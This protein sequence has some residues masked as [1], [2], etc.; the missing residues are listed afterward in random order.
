MWIRNSCFADRLLALVKEWRLP[1]CVGRAAAGLIVA[2]ISLAGF[3][4]ASAE[5]CKAAAYPI[6]SNEGYEHDKWLR[7]QEAGDLKFEF[8]G[9]ISI[10]DGLDDDDSN[11]DLPN[12]LSQPEYVTQEIH[13][14]VEGGMFLYPAGFSRPSKWY[15]FSKFTGTPTKTGV[16]TLKLDGSYT[17]EGTVW[18]RGHMATRNLVNRVSSE[19]GCNSHDFANAI[20]QYWSLNQGEWLALENYAGAL[21]NK[22][23]TAW[24]ISGPIF[25]P[26]AEVETIGQDSEV[27]IPIPHEVFKVII[28]EVED[29]IF[30]RAY[31]FQQPTYHQVKAIMSSNGDKPPLMGFHLCRTTDQEAYD[32]TPYASTLSEIERLTGIIF[33]PAASASEKSALNDYSSRAIWKIDKQFFEKPCGEEQPE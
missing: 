25:L 14:Y 26:D 8:Q 4:E 11:A 19:A 9:F 22:Y 12:V 1:R 21:A 32:F 24:Q 15:E 13:R 31:L 3:H 5:T 7:G 23:G 28:F 29:D 16:T 18:N 10:Y 27:R 20:P 6:K 2:I 33:F 30:V 17:G